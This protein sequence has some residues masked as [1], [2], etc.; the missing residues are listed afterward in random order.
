[1]S[2]IIVL[3]FFIFLVGCASDVS[4]PGKVNNENDKNDEYVEFQ[5]DP[6][7]ENLN[8]NLY[9]LG[10][11]NIPVG[12]VMPY[13][14]R[15]SNSFYIPYLLDIW[16]DQTNERH[17][18]YA[19]TT[20]NFYDYEKLPAGEVIGTSSDPCDQDYAIGTG[21]FI[22]K[23]GLYYAFYTG[24]NPNHP[25]FCT[26]TKEGVMLATSHSLN[27]SFEKRDDFETIYAPV[28]KPFDHEDNF[29][30][31]FVYQDPETSLYYMILS[32]RK[33]YRGWRGVI[34]QFVSEDLMNWSY[35]GILY[36]GGDTNFFMMETPEVFEMGGTY[37]LLFS[38]IDSRHVYYRKSDS[39]HGPWHKPEDQDRFS[40]V[41]IYAA[42]TASDGRNRYIAAWT[43]IKQGHSDT[44]SALWGGNLVAH[45]LYK[46]SNGDLV[47]KMPE[48][49]SSYVG[50]RDYETSVFSEFGKVESNE[51]KDNSYQLET[52]NEN[53]LSSVVFNPVDSDHYRISTTI[54]FSE[55]DN[56]FGFMFGACDEYNDFFS[57]RVVPNHN[58]LR[59]DK[60]TRNTIYP[61]TE[62]Y[63]DV[64][65]EINAGVDYEVDIVIEN[66]MVVIYV[67]EL[68]ALSSRI[69][70]VRGN[71]WGIYAEK[72]DVSFKNIKVT[73]P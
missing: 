69:Y 22:E 29:R 30:D 54:N 12:D 18:I 37:Y 19:F 60:R 68:V 11:D 55:S 6:K 17:P 23:D 28:S 10:P 25:S 53:E 57:F 26:D 52:D 33:N 46:K 4:G 1:M 32:A 58:R 16:N 7:E 71:H 27:T 56:D 51:S 3:L 14:D 62:P 64:P 13:F 67:N 34:A 47:V 8:Y 38:D 45:Q 42:R 21:S 39:I 36:D 41:G 9:P 59:V 61:T 48:N 20:N 2:K 43:H 31:P 15:I 40:G 5:C 70:R 65:M 66:S 44:G 72:S 49:M 50:Q 24:H 35:E 73:K 63:N